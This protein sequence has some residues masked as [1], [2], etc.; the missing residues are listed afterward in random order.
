[1]ITKDHL[2]LKKP[3]LGLMHNTDHEFIVIQFVF[4]W[5]NPPFLFIIRL[6]MKSSISIVATSIFEQLNR[7]SQ[8]VKIYLIAQFND[9]L[10]FLV[11]IIYQF[12]FLLTHL[13]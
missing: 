2:K 10:A 8:V 3:A 11:I 12:L 7:V 4:R 1:L 6:V 13:R 9:S 5:E